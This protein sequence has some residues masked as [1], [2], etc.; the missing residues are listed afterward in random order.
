MSL[1]SFI[2][3]RPN[4]LDHRGHADKQAA[5]GAPADP[6]QR[7]SGKNPLD[8]PCRGQ[9]STPRRSTSPTPSRRRRHGMERG[10]R[11][12]SA[13]APNRPC[14][15]AT[16]SSSCR[17]AWSVPTASRSRR[18]WP[19]AAVHHHL[20]RKGLRTSVGL[21]V[22]TG[23]AREMH[24]F[25][26]LAGYGAE[27]IN[28]YLAFETLADMADEFPGSRR[29]RGDQA[30][31]QVGRQGPAQGHVEDGHLDLPVLLRR[32]DL[33]R[34]R[35]VEELRRRLFHRH[36]HADRR[37]RAGRDRQGNR[38]A[39]P[40]GFRQRAD[41][42]RR[43]RRR[44]RLRL[45]HARRSA[46]LDAR[47]PCRCCSTP[48]AATVQDKYRAY[49]QAAQRAGRK[50]A[51]ASAACSASRAR[52]RTAAAGRLRRSRA[53]QSKSSSAS[54]PAPCRSARFPAKRIPRSPSP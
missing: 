11:T 37:R 48:C 29:L 43:A 28:P 7:R 45:S 18:C 3:P 10:A 46:Y 47:T 33:R 13:T 32:A 53:G 1:V 22:E 26:L 30:L 49:R 27:A 38:G 50:P 34:G 20:I 40:V 9:L 14:A 4:L 31:H 36:G 41:L 51:D 52:R 15:A 21:V 19:R 24:H 6:D 25:A 39:P 42:S 5:R 44:R 54:P 17:T 23:E 16:T 35:P 2:G 12:R 8:R